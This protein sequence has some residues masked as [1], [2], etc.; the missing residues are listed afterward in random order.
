MAKR[1]VVLQASRILAGSL[2]QMHEDVNVLSQALSSASKSRTDLGFSAE[3]CDT[4][5]TKVDV[6]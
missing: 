6:T 3:G 1:S 2:S 4:V 5:T